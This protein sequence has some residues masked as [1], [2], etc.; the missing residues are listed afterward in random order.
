M[1]LYG[2]DMVV[3]SKE[4]AALLKKKRKKSKNKEGHGTEHAC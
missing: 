4:E 1:K 3:S 2:K